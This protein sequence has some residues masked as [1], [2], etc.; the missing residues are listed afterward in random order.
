MTGTPLS[1]GKT[2]RDQSANV[3]NA[4]K[5]RI[6]GAG[7]LCYTHLPTTGALAI[8][9]GKEK[10]TPGWKQGSNKWSSFSGKVEPHEKAFEGAAREFVEESLAM[11]PLET[12]P[13]D[14]PVKIEDVAKILAA[15]EAEIG[16]T[17]VLQVFG[18]TE[19]CRYV[20]YI[21]HIPYENY[22]ERFQE[23]RKALLDLDRTFRTFQTCR[24]GA[25]LP[26]C[27]LPGARLSPVLVVVSIDLLDDKTLSILVFDELEKNTRSLTLEIPDRLAQSQIVSL[28]SAWR[29]VMTSLSTKDPVLKHPAIVVHRLHGYV[30]GAFVKKS[31][32][33]KSEIRWWNLND[34][35]RTAMSSSGSRCGSRSCIGE[36]FRHYFL[37]SVPLLATAVR[38]R[39]QD[40]PPSFSS[41]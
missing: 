24:K 29:E 36:S 15:D 33:E 16:S 5:M 14:V 25:S 40:L 38:R 10:E 26:R 30:V 17:G 1:R 3:R 41:S 4:Y 13:G 22:P 31:Y 27:V 39:V 12:P 7:V 11:V 37:E 20:V 32:L 19:E 2:E 8:L 23:A 28:V 6:S 18:K 34:L 9:L 35:E 21:R